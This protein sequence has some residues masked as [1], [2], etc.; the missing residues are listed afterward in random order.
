M[1]FISMMARGLAGVISDLTD[2]SEVEDKSVEVFDSLDEAERH[3]EA[4][5]SALDELQ[6]AFDEG[7][8]IKRDAVRQFLE[9]ASAELKE[10]EYHRYHAVN[11]LSG[12]E[13]D[14]PDL[15]EEAQSIQEVANFLD[16]IDSRGYETVMAWPESGRTS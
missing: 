3:I 7:G 16:N 6:E 10:I 15:E 1:S 2:L 4:L 5:S 11:E 8:H 12:M 14:P 9:V 13:L